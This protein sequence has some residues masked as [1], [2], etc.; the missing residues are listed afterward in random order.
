MNIYFS[1][2]FLWVIIGF[3]PIAG[4]ISAS[5]ISPALL[6]LIS[7]A[8]AG[9]CFLPWIHK[10]KQWGN[11]FNKKTAGRFFLIASFGTAAPF[12]M[13][14]LALRYTS[15]INSAVLTQFE[16]VYSF[17][18][19]YFLLGERPGRK[20]ILGSL[21]VVAGAVMILVQ[22][23]FSIH[24]KGDLMVIGSVWMFQLSSSMAKKLP[25]ELDYRVIAC[26]RALYALPL[27]ALIVFYTWASGD[28]F[29]V[30]GSDALSVI[31]YTALLKNG[32]AMVFWYRAI[33]SIS[34]AKVTAF[35]LSYPALS[36]VISLA[37]G[38]EA[39]TCQKFLGL[40]FAVSGALVISNTIK[41]ENKGK[42]EKTNT[43]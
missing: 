20:Q 2:F 6:I 7:A 22:D 35:Y 9:C 33:R 25:K 14:L 12:Y 42:Y 29:F 31:L 15:P 4:K 28:L 41:E 19:A 40:A 34:L 10:N 27:L 23:A 1:L 38:M 16:L 24:L 36:F 17:L 26:A 32:L 43:I 3:S 37:L 18:F 8:I 30:F 39:F 5:V 21:L 13:L 11:L